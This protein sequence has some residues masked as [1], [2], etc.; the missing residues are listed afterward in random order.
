[1]PKKKL[2]QVGS[3]IIKESG[4]D[5]FYGTAVMSIVFGKLEIP[6]EVN[7]YQVEAVGPGA[8]GDCKHLTE[9]VLPAS[10]TRIGD[11]AFMNTGLTTMRLPQLTHLGEGALSGCD[12][13]TEI[14]IPGSLKKVDQFAFSESEYLEKVVI[15]SGVTEISRCA[16]AFCYRLQTLEWQSPATVKKIGSL[17][18]K[19]TDFTSVTLPASLTMIGEGAFSVCNSLQK[20]VCEAEV[21]PTIVEVR[22]A[23]YIFDGL[24]DDAT[25]HVPQ[26]S[27]EAYS[28]APG[29][30]V[31]LKLGGIHPIAQ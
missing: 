26:G 21:P 30:N 5:I 31:F 3:G 24:P 16:F 28:Q 14:E 25:L 27:V 20:V 18:F 17:A 11:W 15:Q 12:Q 22:D 9:V 19:C 4:E 23:E 8:F 2:C 10:V 1:M 7:G 29:W 6:A 13:L